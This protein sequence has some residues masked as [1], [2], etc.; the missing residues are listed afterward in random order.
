M[1]LKKLRDFKFDRGWKYLVYFD[2]LLP[3]LFF[4]IALLTQSPFMAKIFHSYEM[5]IV[6]P[7]PD[8]KTLTGIIGFAYHLGI[9]GYAI[10]KRDY[11]D[12]GVSAVLTLL[13]TAMFIF[14]INYVIVRPL[15]FASF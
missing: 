15:N 11:I 9:I 2:F 3:A 10:K 14:A 8:I 4:L 7:I 12:L 6:N 1:N 13:I 5:F